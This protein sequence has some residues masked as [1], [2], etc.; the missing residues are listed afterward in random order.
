MTLIKQIEKYE[1]LISEGL[2]EAS[3]ISSESF[4]KPKI[5]SPVSSSKFERRTPSP[6]K[7]TPE[8]PSISSMS[9]VEEEIRDRDS[10][11]VE[12]PD[13][14]TS[15]ILASPSRA[16]TPSPQKLI[17]EHIS[18]VLE[19]RSSP[20]ISS[21]SSSPVSKVKLIAEGKVPEILPQTPEKTRSSVGNQVAS[22]DYSSE[23]DSDK[24]VLDKKEVAGRNVTDKLVDSITENI[25]QQIIQE[26]KTTFSKSSK[27]EE[28]PVRTSPDKTRLSKPKPRQT[29]R[30][31]ELT[32]AFDVGSSSEDSSPALVVEE[33]KS[34]A[35]EQGEG[36]ELQ[37][38][39]D[40]DFGLSNIRAEEEILRLEQLRVEEEILI[41]Q[42]ESSLLSSVPD[43]P[44]PPY[45][46]PPDTPPPP[47]PAPPKP[48]KVLLPQQKDEILPILEDFV[49]IIHEAKHKGLDLRTLSCPPDSVTV[50]D[51]FNEIEADTLRKY[52]GMLFSVTLEKVLEIFKFETLVQNP[53]W[54]EQLPL[55]RMKFSAP[56]TLLDLVARVQREVCSDLKLMKR[57]G[58]EN[59]LVSWAGKK[60][61]RVDEIL[62]RELQ[63][64]EVLWTNYNEDEGMVKD[65]MTDILVESLI[66][67]TARVFEN[68][69]RGIKNS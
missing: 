22:T 1:Q 42:R 47:R 15:T 20:V 29:L 33:E 48:T 21:K 17:S 60:R 24:S 69:Y 61:D 58:R 8:M 14:S 46:P 31:Q 37:E 66:T 67:D 23:F 11:T 25:W 34:E 12:S 41:L 62:V 5:K 57:V 19:D 45:Q 50:P 51:S 63:E 7:T 55:A 26:T 4:S 52:H 56:Q 39:L 43:K 40:D 64:E 27:Q 54:M 18:E 2:A 9:L 38:F 53:P 13:V 35:E 68:I 36:A 10:E 3:D 32:L 49:R 44:P 65:Q 30:S 28:S 16:K 59:L 6:R